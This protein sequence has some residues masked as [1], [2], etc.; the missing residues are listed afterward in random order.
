MSEVV[1]GDVRLHVDVDGEGS[2]VTVLAHGLTNTC[3]E[4]APVTPFLPG[5]KVR[6]CLRGHGH[7]SVAAEGRYTFADF[8]SDVEAVADTHGATRA[9]GTSLGAGAICNLLTRR[10][11]RFEALVFL[12]PAGLDVPFTEQD[13]FLKTAEILETHP[14]DEA[15]ELILANPE[16]PER[17]ARLAWM[18]EYS[19]QMWEGV[20][21]MGV[22]RAIRGVI[23]DFPL[24]DREMMRAV[25]ARTLIICREGD[26]IHPVVVG[27]VLADIMPNAELLVYP[28]DGALAGAAPEL[29]MRAAEVLS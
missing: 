3:R 13:H 12:L 5:T 25:H 17:S 28:D 4:M 20:N 18:D 8:A 14:R 6:F 2:P 11:D 10:P 27:E 16:A 24:P 1:N 29:V 19:R 21:P 15:I 7:S 22:A 23:A 9:V 26:P